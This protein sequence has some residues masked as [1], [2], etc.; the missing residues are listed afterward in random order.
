[1]TI[2]YVLDWLALRCTLDCVAAQ[3]VWCELNIVISSTFISDVEHQHQLDIMY[4]YYTTIQY[5]HDS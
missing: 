5:N 4:L 1:M 2:I 3:L